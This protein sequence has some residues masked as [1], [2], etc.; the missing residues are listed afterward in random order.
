MVESVMSKTFCPLPWNHLCTHPHGEVTLC[1][2]VEMKDSI[3]NAKNKSSKNNLNLN[4]C[5]ID[6]IVNSDSFKKVRLDMLEGKAPAACDKCFNQ[7]SLGVKSRRIKEIQKGELE[8]EKALEL[9]HKETGEIKPNISSTEL[10]LGNRCNLKCS[11]CNPISSN[12]WMDDYLELKNQNIEFSVDYSGI[13]DEMFSWADD[14]S[15]WKDLNSQSE[16]LKLININGGEPTLIK[17]HFNFLKVLIDSNRSKYIELDY[18]IN[19]TNLPSELTTLWSSFKEVTI[20]VSIDDKSERNNFIRYPSKWPKIIENLE[21]LTSLDVK[22]NLMQTISIYNFLTV[23][24]L[25]L[26]ISKKIDLKLYSVNEVTDPS[27]LSPLC[28]PPKI[29]KMKLKSIFGLI[30]LEEYKKL[31][32]LYNNDIFDEKGLRTFL[33]YNEILKSNRK[34]NFENDFS[35]LQSFID[36]ETISN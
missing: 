24:E 3:G 18:N 34:N 5:S 2:H 1:C 22:I 31:I 26:D 15:F 23:E 6:E 7:E 17:A 20:N 30:P 8:F 27:F 28:I 11:T 21:K 35:E 10:R 14:S 36:S 13:R 12:Q 32:K 9:T 19:L 33:R 4:E 25:Y 29:R 16:Q